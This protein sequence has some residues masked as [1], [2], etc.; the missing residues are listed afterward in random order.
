MSQALIS[1]IPATQKPLDSSKV[2][3]SPKREFT[4]FFKKK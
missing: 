1:I 3:E 4:F 2:D